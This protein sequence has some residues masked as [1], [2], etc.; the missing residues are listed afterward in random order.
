C[1]NASNLS[2]CKLST[3]NVSL[4]EETFVQE[5]QLKGTCWLCKWALNKVKKSISTSSMSF[6][7]IPLFT[8]YSLVKKHFWVLIEELSTSDDVRTICVNIK[9]C[10]PKEY[11]DSKVRRWMFRCQDNAMLPASCSFFFQTSHNTSI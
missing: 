7:E 4:Y 10:K 1:F 11:P 9:A 3:S 6:H 8:I 2:A 5:Q